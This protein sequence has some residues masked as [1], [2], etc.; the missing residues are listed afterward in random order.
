[1][2]AKA[3]TKETKTAEATK[4]TYKHQRIGTGHREDQGGAQ[5]T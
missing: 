2:Q 4:A 1:M 3:K 5:V